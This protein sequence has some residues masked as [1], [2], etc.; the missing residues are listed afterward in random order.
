MSNRL[1]GSTK[2]VIA[3][4]K[5]KHPMKFGNK[6]T[7][8]NFQIIKLFILNGMCQVIMLRRKGS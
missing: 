7:R 2:G 8:I 3:V 6:I 1:F 5:L 4:E